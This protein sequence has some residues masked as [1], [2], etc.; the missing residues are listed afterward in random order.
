MKEK[1]DLC[2]IKLN[3]KDMIH[4]VDGST[5]C[6]ECLDDCNKEQILR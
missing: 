4:L 1:C 2:N 6:E 3:K 5:V